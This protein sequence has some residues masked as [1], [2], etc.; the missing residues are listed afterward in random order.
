MTTANQQQDQNQDAIKAA[1]KR[2]CASLQA[3]G[4]KVAHTAMLEA[5]AQGFGLDN[6]RT[7]KAVIDAPRAAAIPAEPAKPAVPEL[8][9]WQ[10]WTVEAIYEDN[11]QQYSDNFEGRT[12]LEGAINALMDRWTD[13]HNVI[14][15]CDVS[16]ASGK[17][18][19]S[20]SFITEIGLAR[21]ATVLRTLARQAMAVHAAEGLKLPYGPE[22]AWLL[23]ELGGVLEDPKPRS[24]FEPVPDEFEH[25]TDYDSLDESRHPAYA[26]PARIGGEDDSKTPKQ[27]LEYLLDLVEQHHGGVLK[28]EAADEDLA[29]HL[30]QV[31]AMCAYFEKVVNDPAL[32]FDEI[33]VQD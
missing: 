21:T 18:R 26:H 33:F 23:A 17:S 13:F 20:P 2:M 22:L 8:G 31:R 3:K 6:W 16:D 27:A 29:K 30:Y 25:L 9:Q 14:N 5:L 10:M 7:L 1:A 12:P 28:L 32:G 11:N 15:I 24:I 4:H 19:L